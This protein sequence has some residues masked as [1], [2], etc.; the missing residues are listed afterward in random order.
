LGEGNPEVVLL[1]TGSEVQLI[2]GAGER[3]AAAGRNV[4]LVSFP[5]WDLFEKQE[6]AY[7]DEVL[8]PEITTRISVEAGVSQGWE[9][10]TG[11]HQGIISVDRYGASAPYKIVYEE[12]G[13]TVDAVFE[14]AITLLG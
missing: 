1:A 7:R 12:L 8:P 5:S 9:R 2:V 6:Q 10:W 4:R 14:K 13:L 3:L 11:S